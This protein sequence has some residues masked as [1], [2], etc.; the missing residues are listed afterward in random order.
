MR[1]PYCFLYFF[2]GAHVRGPMCPLHGANSN[3]TNAPVIMIPRPNNS[4]SV[5]PDRS[6]FRLREQPSACRERRGAATRRLCTR[7]DEH[8]HGHQNH[9]ILASAIQLGDA[10]VPR[11]LT[12]A[13]ITIAGQIRCPKY[14]R[15]RVSDQSTRCRDNVDSAQRALWGTNTHYRFPAAWNGS[16]PKTSRRDAISHR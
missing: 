5:H 14:R 16:L 13:I 2:T 1:D 10:D 6:R 3:P 11:S 9:L 7:R 12:S 4:A 8:S 15:V